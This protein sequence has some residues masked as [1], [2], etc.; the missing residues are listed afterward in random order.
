MRHTSSN[1]A[2]VD[3]VHG[4]VVRLPKLLRPD[5]NQGLVGG[6]GRAVDRL[7]SYAESG[8]CRRDENDSA[9]AGNVRDDGLGQEN[10]TLNIG[11]KVGGEQILGYFI[12]VC[13]NA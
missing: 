13:I 11:I 9:A 10:R 2:R 8:S 7:S 3:A 6:F 5:P 1:R 4:N 12:Q